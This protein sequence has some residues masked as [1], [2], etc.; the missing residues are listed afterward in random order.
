MTT[1]KEILDAKGNHVWSIDMNASMFDAI[2]LMAEKEV[3]AL[4]VTDGDR[5]AGI[6][7]ERDYTC[8]VILKGRTSKQTRVVE[9]MTTGVIT[10]RGDQTIQEC[11]ALMTERR[12]RHLPVLDGERMAGMLSI[13]DL[14]KAVIA[15]QLFTI[16]QLEGYI[17][18]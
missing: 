14:V 5:L 9:I 11:M 18:G 15:H 1:V 7:S 12:V 17:R 10:V 4:A 16:E 6:I 2:K 13:G 3:G 8:K